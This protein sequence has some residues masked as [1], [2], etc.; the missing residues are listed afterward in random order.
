MRAGR[1]S[2]MACRLASAKSFRAHG[3][4]K[5]RKTPAGTGRR[6]GDCAAGW[7]CD[8]AF[9][10]V[11]VPWRVGRGACV[12]G[13]SANRCAGALD[14]V[15]ADEA[16]WPSVAQDGPDC[17][18]AA[19]PRFGS[20]TAFGQWKVGCG[21]SIGL[22]PRPNRCEGA[23][24]G[25]Q[26]ALRSARTAPRAGIV[27]IFA[28]VC[29]L[30]GFPIVKAGPMRDRRVGGPLSRSGELCGAKP[31]QCWKLFVLPEPGI[32]GFLP[33]WRRSARPGQT[34][35]QGIFLDSGKSMVFF[36]KNLAGMRRR[37]RR[38]VVSISWTRVR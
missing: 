10:A 23:S 21:H 35:P 12:T 15:S 14:R 29:R 34:S 33:S 11:F 13:L 36:P 6:R 28:R 27:Q 2:D 18:G 22:N 3:C 26:V 25:G 32:C 4:G 5:L 24:E 8:S 17:A 31:C 9:W 19:A 16:V 30:V 38:E 37:R 20:G 7:R 1:T